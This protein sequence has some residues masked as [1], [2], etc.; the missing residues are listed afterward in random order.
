MTDRGEEAP[1][2]FRQAV[3]ALA[4]ARP[5]AEV[6]FAPLPAPRRLAP[7]AHAL[8]AAVAADGAGDEEEAADGRFVLLHDPAG[9]E[10]WRGEFRVVTLVRAGLEPE[11]AADPLLPEVAWSWLTEALQGRGLAHRAASGTVTR[12]G[13]SFFG[14]LSDRPAHAELELRAS[15]TPVDARDAGAH[16]LAWCDLLAQCAGLPPETAGPAVRTLP[17]RRGPRPA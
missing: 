6:S 12:A 1:P 14:G 5:R 13:S 3:A 10:G 9:D 16:L 7:F 15:W 17:R 11:L 2:A 8:G 4:A